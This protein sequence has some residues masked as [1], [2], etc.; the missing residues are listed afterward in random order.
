MVELDG[1]SSGGGDGLVLAAGSAR[2]HDQGPGHRRVQRR[3]AIR[4]ESA[5]DLV[6][7]DELGVTSAGPTGGNRIGVLIDGAAAAT[8]GGTAAGAGDLI[9]F[10]PRP[11]SRSSAVRRSPTP[12]L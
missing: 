7:S 9:G 4:V 6:A 3:A 5:G 8:I 10:N 11:A 2:Q 1:A 12:A